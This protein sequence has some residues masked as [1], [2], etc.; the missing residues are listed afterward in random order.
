MAGVTHSALQAGAHGEL[1]ARVRSMVLVGC[2]ALGLT[3]ILS[4]EACHWPL[5]VSILGSLLIVFALLLVALG[6]W[7][8]ASL[9]A[10]V[11][12][13]LA[14]GLA[15]PRLLSSGVAAC[16]LPVPVVL[17]SLLFGPRQGTLLATLLS[18]LLLFAGKAV[19]VPETLSRL[20]A[21]AGLWAVHGLAWAA[22]ASATQ[23][24]EWWSATYASMRELLE[25][26]R[27][28]R[29]VLKQTE[30][31]L[32]HANQELA[33]VS[34]RLQ[35]L[36]HVADEARRAKEEFVANVSHELRTPLNMI[37]GFSEMITEGP[38]TYG[39]DLPPALLSDIT[40]IRR[41]SEH[42]I[43]LVDDVL[44]LSQS[45]AGYL[46]LSKEWTSPH[47][48]WLSAASIVRPLFE[49]KGLSL[50]GEVPEELPPILCDRTRI[51]QVLVNLLSNAG[52]FTERGGVRVTIRPGEGGIVVSVADT[53]PGIAA[54]DQA[55]LFQPFQRPRGAAGQSGG[56]GLGLCISR[57]FVEMH[58]GRVWL[59]SEVGKGTTVHFSLP[60]GREQLPATVDGDAMRGIVPDWEYKART[61]ASRAPKT[62]LVPRFV[63]LEKGTTV[64]RLLSTHMAGA[65][66]SP[67][68]EMA[69][70]LA[71]LQRS[72]ANGLVVNAP[73]ADNGS[74]TVPKGLPYA[75]PVMTC[76]LPDG[77]DLGGLPGA[78]SY[79]VK[80]VTRKILLSTL[81]GLGGGLRRLL[82]V[83]DDAEMLQLLT[84]IL[85]SAQRGYRV[86]RARNGQRALSLLRERKPD[87]MLLDLV[88]PGSDGFQV[89]REK[90]RDAAIRH[91]P[92]VVISARDP[93]NEPIVSESLRVAR[94]GGLTASELVACIRS[95][96]TI[97]SP[98]AP[99]VGRAPTGTP[100]G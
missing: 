49:A 82:V 99:T 78:M 88:M 38:G 81:D 54:D 17:A 59:E 21:V 98:P 87:A 68:T 67:V 6:P 57:R 41:N 95:L 52:R 14:I 24:T 34:A 83:D 47:Q 29:L 55:R 85:A 53:G 11:L 58:G 19:G 86:L 96:T 65:E 1:Q 3:F 50:D 42:L 27:A 22:L 66:I 43:K 30:A 51:R 5:Q 69:A 33:R 63:V 71:E 9:W 13:C 79:L 15:S 77:G 35:A 93:H 39:V 90:Q 61:R 91:I 76:W 45:E 89:L 40:I 56:T 4:A 84:R 94:E 25:E 92:V 75:T 97:L 73:P 31:D 60:V 62:Q 28:Q 80:P 36:L 26:A 74:Q 100:D 72:P 2:G 64:Q 32:V 44:A 20:I 12:G 18:L 70:A 8:R 7:Q 23:A 37:I 10:L 48:I 46:V 16:L